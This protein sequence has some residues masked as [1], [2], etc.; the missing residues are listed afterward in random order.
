M[1]EKLCSCKNKELKDIVFENTSV[2]KL[3][4]EIWQAGDKKINRI[5]KDFGIPSISE[6]GKA[7]SYLQT[8]PRCQL[9]E[10]R[11]LNDVV[12]IPVG[13]TE[14]HGLALPSGSDTLFVTQM[15]EG[16]RRYTEKQGRPVS[17]A[18]PPTMYGA[19]PYHHL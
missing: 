17:L 6:L 9:E 10:E 13:S 4:K 19:H 3:E 18:H 16:V 11:R 5:L 15:L 2:G 7:G 12:L 8:T 1:V 14:N